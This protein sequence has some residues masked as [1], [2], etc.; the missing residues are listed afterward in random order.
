MKRMSQLVRAD[1]PLE[2]ELHGLAAIGAVVG[3][4][5]Y[6]LTFDWKYFFH[7]FVL[8]MGEAHK[9]GFQ[10]PQ[11]A[12]AGGARALMRTLLEVVLAMGS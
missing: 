10:L 6:D 3:L 2:E 9:M 7:L 4:L 1:E 11:R 12:A 8:F 5:V